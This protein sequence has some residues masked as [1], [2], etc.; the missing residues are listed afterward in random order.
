MQKTNNKETEDCFL[1]NIPFLRAFFSARDNHNII[2]GTPS[3]RSFQPSAASSVASAAS[4]AAEGGGASSSVASLVNQAQTNIRNSCTS[5][6]KNSNTS[7]STANIETT[8]MDFKNADYRGFVFAVH[9][10]HGYLLL[11]CTR[12]KKKPN[13]FQLPGG[14]IDH[15]EFTEAATKANDPKEQLVLAGKVGAARELYEE[16]GMDLR[17]SLDRVIP[18]RLYDENQLA[19]MKLK[20][21]KVVNEYKGRLF[22]TVRVTDHDFL[23]GEDLPIAD[24]AFLQRP[25]GAQPPNLMLKLSHEHQGFAFEQDPD[26]AVTL[27]Q[28]HSGG[29]V[30]KALTMSTAVGQQQR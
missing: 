9:P 14:H 8:N 17:R 23:R 28:H 30:S 10:E 13:H 16:T 3:S 7:T 5:P 29:K 25:M 24:A 20:N 6:S 2:V 19:K 26:I 4:S 18:T 22:F 15:F 11:H 1:C 21:E 12:K 27:L